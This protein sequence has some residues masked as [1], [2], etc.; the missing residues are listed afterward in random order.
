M[1]I[2]MYIYIYIY[3]YVFVDGQGA[4]GQDSGLC[5]KTLPAKIFQGLSFGGVRVHIM[6]NM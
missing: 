1:C 2:C 5:A 6:S 4:K 3:I